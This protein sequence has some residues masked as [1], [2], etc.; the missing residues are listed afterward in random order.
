MERFSQQMLDYAMNRYLGLGMNKDKDK[1][2]ETVEEREEVNGIDVGK[3]KE[4][5]E[6]VIRSTRTQDDESTE[7]DSYKRPIER[8]YYLH[9]RSRNEEEKI[10]QRDSPEMQGTSLPVSSHRRHPPSH[11]SSRNLKGQEGH[12]TKSVNK[13]GLRFGIGLEKELEDMKGLLTGLSLQSLSHDQ[14]DREFCCRFIAQS[15]QLLFSMGRIVGRIR[16]I[17]GNTSIV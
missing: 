10:H 2:G 15:D 16:E 3:L 13:H 6:Q 17:N 7:A 9:G 4:L 1:D 5:A 12:D 11:T 8:G 14:P